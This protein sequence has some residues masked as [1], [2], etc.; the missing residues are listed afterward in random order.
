MSGNTS[1]GTIAFAENAFSV[2]AQGAA[3]TAALERHPVVFAVR[4]FA[5]A[6]LATA[7]SEL[8]YMATLQDNWDSYGAFPVDPRCIEHA[9]DLVHGLAY[10]ENVEVPV[11]GPTPDG[12]VG[13]SW[14]E[15]D[16]S[17]DAEVLPDGR[18]EYVYLDE[19]DSTKDRETITSDWRELLELLTQWD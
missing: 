13:F 12:H 6:W 2:P 1:Q 8:H 10:C 4:P 15:G 17:L 9:I 18:I 14:D 16:W 19:R 3:E 11:V 5:Q 7:T